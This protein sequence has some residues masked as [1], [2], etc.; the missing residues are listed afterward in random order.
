MSEKVAI[1][2][3][4]GDITT[5]ACDAVMLKYARAHY[6]VDAI[7]ANLIKDALPR[8]E[9][10]PPEKKFSIVPTGNFLSAGA[11]VFIGTP[12][13]TRF[14]YQDVMKFSQMAMEIAADRRNAFKHVAFT[15]HG[16]GF[17]LDE[18]EAAR[19]LVTGCV[20]T[21]KKNRPGGPERIS[22][23]E[24]DPD[25]Y[26]RVTGDFREYLPLLGLSVGEGDACWELW[27]G[28]PSIAESPA[29]AV[30]LSSGRT[31]GTGPFVFVAMPFAQEFDDTYHYGI[32]KPVHESGLLCE[33][34]DQSAFTGDILDQV[35]K[36]IRS[37][38]LVVAELTGG[39]ANVYLEVG[40]AWGVGTPTVLLA[41]ADHKLLFD[42]Q[43]QRCLIY[44][45]I[46]QL[47][48]KLAREIAQLRESRS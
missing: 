7:I 8:A 48:E 46:K 36:K 41:R 2:V 31:L 24:L 3:V 45:G 44:G 12:S 43:G 32:Y 19:A 26:R 22:I 21:L 39:N 25:R 38:W 16:A 9:T 5:F 33:R 37:A 6:G 13:L 30:T 20:S 27:G 1:S 42:V 11:A 15:L 23:V 17:G 40:Y 18:L 34:I 28:P 29:P 35:K 14:S 4:R 47:E 10:E